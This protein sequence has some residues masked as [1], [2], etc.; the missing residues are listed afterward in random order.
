[1]LMHPWHAIGNAASFYG[2]KLRN[3]FI[4]AKLISGEEKKNP[5]IFPYHDHDTDP[6]GPQK[7]FQ[8]P[9][10]LP[11]QTPAASAKLPAWDAV[12]G[13]IMNQLQTLGWTKAQA[14]GMAANIQR[15]SQGNPNAIGDHGESYGIGQWN[16]DRQKEFS[17][18]PG[19]EG[20][21]IIGS[22]L[23][24]QIKFMN[25]ELRQGKFKNVGEDLSNKVTA[26]GASDLLTKRYEIPANMSFEASVRRNYASTLMQ[27]TPDMKIEPS[28]LPVAGQKVEMPQPSAVQTPMLPTAT[29]MNDN[30]TV[31]V[32]INFANAPAG[33]K[34][35]V[36]STG[37]VSTDVKIAHSMPGNI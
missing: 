21:S 14:A 17:K 33:M 12:S 1:M 31:K 23:S 34:S 6:E 4:D 15:E 19:Y 30:G 32:N 20:K 22:S 2:T 13:Q 16:K 35:S 5:Y 27:Q 18:M 28:P 25:Y 29:S 24:D 10:I 3:S 7:P 9:L 37:P 8:T 11:T 36:A 26:T